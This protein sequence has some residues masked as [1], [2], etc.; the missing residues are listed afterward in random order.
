MSIHSWPSDS[1]FSTSLSAVSFNC[2][3]FFHDCFGMFLN[4][5]S[6]WHEHPEL[7]MQAVEFVTMQHDDDLWEELIK[8]CLRKPE[9]VHTRSKTRL[10]GYFPWYLYIM[11]IIV[12]VYNNEQIGMLL[13]HT[14]GNLDPL[15]IVKK[16]PDG[17]E[18]PRWEWII[19]SIIFCTSLLVGPST[20][21]H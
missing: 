16:V 6:N 2:C 10:H 5:E 20:S 14:V 3:L 7:R 4:L 21:G 19:S 15:Y 12:L 11:T 9:M 1:P 13:E 8:Q 18:I 17:L